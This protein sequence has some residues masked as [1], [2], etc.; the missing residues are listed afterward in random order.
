MRFFSRE[1]LTEYVVNLE[2]LAWTCKEWQA[3]GI[4]CGDA[5]PVALEREEDPPVYQQLFFSANYIQLI[6]TQTFYRL[7]AYR[8]TYTNPI[9]HP[10][11]GDA[12]IMSV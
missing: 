7:T 6:T 1:T 10:I 3:T 11:S 9:F 5:L 8:N 2:L 12:N 4:P